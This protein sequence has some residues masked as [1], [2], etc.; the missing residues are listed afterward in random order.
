M[1]IPFVGVV[2]AESLEVCESSGMWRCKQHSKLRS[3]IR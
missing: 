2:S 3:H 1:S